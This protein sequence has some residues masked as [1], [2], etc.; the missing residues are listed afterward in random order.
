VLEAVRKEL[1]GYPGERASRV[2][3][4][5]GEFAAVDPES[6]RFCLEVIVKSSDLAPLSVEIE[7]CHAGAGR[8]GDE[9]EIA[10]L[11]LEEAPYVVEVPA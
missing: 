6:L 3:L 4:R 10:F 2:G 8:R 9:L 1:K 11:E 5:I 7:W